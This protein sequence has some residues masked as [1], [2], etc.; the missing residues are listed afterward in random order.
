[1]QLTTGIV[2]LLFRRDW[3]VH[4]KGLPHY[5]RKIIMRVPKAMADEA[6][7]RFGDV[8]GKEM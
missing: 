3:M 5:K 7:R 2:L 1:M 6:F 8:D 4:L